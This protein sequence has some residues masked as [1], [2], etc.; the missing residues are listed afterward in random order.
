[1][2]INN[3]FDFCLDLNESKNKVIYFIG[4]MIQNSLFTIAI[5]NDSKKVYSYSN[6]WLFLIKRYYPSNLEYYFSFVSYYNNIV[7]TNELDNSYS[8]YDVIPFI[9]SFSNGTVH[10]YSGLFFILNEYINNY[11][12]Y[13]DYKILVYKDCQQGILDIINHFVNKNIM[14]EEKIIHISSNKQYLFSSIKFIPNKWHMFPNNLKLE[15]ID[16]YI[17]EKDNLTLDNDK[18]C[19]IKSS[20]STNVTCDGIVSFETIE[21]FCNKHNLLLVE[22][23]KMNEIQLIN[24]INKLKTFVTSWGTS[25]LKNYIYISDKC[26]KIIVLIIGTNFLNQYNSFKENGNVQTKYKNA[27]IS[28]HVVN[29]DLDLDV[30]KLINE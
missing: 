27:T 9:T 24:L 4:G 5:D 20:R 12:N 21:R 14:N 16:N 10:G 7:S 3:I 13:K 19:I 23:T 22:P 26:E 18:I 17:V 8:S 11:E 15:L 30:L 25:F 28:Y 1:M 29:F 6:E 2:N